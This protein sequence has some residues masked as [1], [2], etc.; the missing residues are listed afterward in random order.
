MI[1]VERDLPL[2]MAEID[3]KLAKLTAA[4]ESGSDDAVREA[5]H[6]VVPTFRTQEEIN[7]EAAKSEE[8]NAVRETVAVA[9]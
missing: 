3:R 4:V 8:M 1:F 6:E 5:L 2:S 7:A 9:G